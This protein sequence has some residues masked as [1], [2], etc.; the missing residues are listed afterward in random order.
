MLHPARTVCSPAREAPCIGRSHFKFQSGAR[1]ADQIFGSAYKVG[2]T[3]L[4][5]V[6]CW[7]VKQ[8]HHRRASRV[9][10]S[11]V[12]HRARRDRETEFLVDGDTQKVAGCIYAI[13]ELRKGGRTVFTTVYVSR[14]G[15]DSW[16]MFKQ[17]PHTC[18]CS[19]EGSGA[20]EDVDGVIVE[21]LSHLAQ[22]ADGA[23]LALLAADIDYVDLVRNIVS[24]KREIV[25]FV[26]RNAVSSVLA[27]QE[28]GARVIPLG[29][30][31]EGPKVRAFLE[32][33]GSGRVETAE[34]WQA[35]RRED[36]A[37][38]ELT[39]FLQ[40]WGYRGERGYLI[41]SV[42]KFWFAHDLGRLTVFPAQA[43]C[44]AAHQQIKDA[45]PGTSWI[46]Y[47]N[48]LAFFLPIGG[49]RN[50]SH[51]VNGPYGGELPRRV[52]IGAGPFIVKDSENMVLEVLRR[53]GYL[54]D[55]VNNDFS[56]AVRRF[57]SQP[58]NKYWLRK[59]CRAMPDDT[60]TKE[61]VM[62][63]LRRA[64][65]S[66]DT[67]DATLLTRKM[68][69]HTRCV[70]L[71]S[72]FLVGKALDMAAIDEAAPTPAG[73]EASTAPPRSNTVCSEG[74]SPMSQTTTANG[75]AIMA[76][77]RPSHS[78]GDVPLP[79]AGQP[80]AQRRTTSSEAPRLGRDPARTAARKKADIPGPT[81]AGT[82]SEAK[83]A[84]ATGRPD[85][86]GPREAHHG[87]APAAA[88]RRKERDG[89]TRTAS[90]NLLSQGPSS[91][92]SMD[93][94]AVGRLLGRGAFGKV[95]V[96]VHKLTEELSAMKQCD[97][98]RLA[99]VGNRKCLQQEVTI[100]KRL[101]G[102]A[103][104]IQLFEVVE[105]PSQIVLVMEF[106][107]GGDLLRYVRTQR[108]LQEPCVKD[109][110]KQL[111][112]GLAHVH[113]MRVVHRDIKL[114]NLLLDPYGCVKIADFGVAVVAQPGKQLHEHCGTPSYIAPEILLEAGYE[115]F[116]A[117][118]RHRM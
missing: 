116:P 76:A 70:S 85:A 98:R 68:K 86:K 64:F 63:K 71:D 42:A 77:R 83:E 89:A 37:A 40:E 52:Y 10:P 87:E 107:N 78:R 82:A 45:S 88:A 106:A 18:L 32:P 115:G 60:D 33:D 8:V 23:C 47:R 80:V 96:A 69:M 27:Y 101:T 53:L 49:E 35:A 84:K 34:P 14:R 9:T 48:D 19:V 59:N 97:R 46:E 92:N 91:T 1:P 57:V 100:M 58:E 43:G 55:E 102:H 11:S 6:G 36:Q 5:T 73:S 41:P 2:W 25:V 94:Y 22:V 17:N 38:D 29:R 113:D 66:H 65:L 39:S 51:E 114:E 16:S 44:A 15:R 117:D 118:V 50:E 7:P 24:A 93:C 112:D 108:R 3:L 109:L 110:F 99:E 67:S 28:T 13:N 26:P 111:M 90:S 54:D 105:T 104:I 79:A 20:G 95:N 103:N 12:S 74:F 62:A 72:S 56:R 61:Q 21:R 4:A 31:Q 81:A 30:I 75:A